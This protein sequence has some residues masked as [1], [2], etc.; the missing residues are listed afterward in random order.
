MIVRVPPRD[1]ISFTELS[2]WKIC[3]R[4]WYNAYVRRLRPREDRRLIKFGRLAHLGMSAFLKGEDWRS[5]VDTAIAEDCKDRFDESIEQQKQLGEEVK[6][7]LHRFITTTLAEF[8]IVRDNNGNPLT[9]F[10]IEVPIRGI[11]TRLYVRVDAVLS[12]GGS[13]HWLAEFKF[14]GNQFRPYDDI[15]MSTQIAIYQFALRRAGIPTVGVLY[16]QAL[17]KQPATPKLNKDGSMSRSDI[18]TTWEVYEKALVENGLNPMDYIDMQPKLADK[19]F[20]TVDRIYRSPDQLRAFQDEL[21]HSAYSLTAPKK[22]ILF[23][24]NAINCRGCQ[25]REI[26]EE[27]ISGRDPSGVIEE[28]F[29]VKDD[30]PETDFNAVNSVE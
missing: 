12:D 22:Y 1:T 15:R 16:F 26:C 11:K 17:G 8:T 9:E 19:K 23:S 10:E 21:A 2:T 5:V 7:V 6:G 4:R 30:V 29:V 18:S 25:F 27:E 3:R 28:M 14:P 13:G 24:D 20:I